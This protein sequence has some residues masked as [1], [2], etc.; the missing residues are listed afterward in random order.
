MKKA[1]LSMFIF[2]IGASS[3]FATLVDDSIEKELEKL[4]I[5]KG[6]ENKPYLDINLKTFKSCEDMEKVMED[7]IKTYWKKNKDKYSYRFGNRFFY[8]VKN[9]E[10][11]WAVMEE[12]VNSVAK[13]SVAPIGWIASS[14]YSKTNTQVKGVDEADIVK[15]DGKYIYYFSN[16]RK[17]E[18]G[19]KKYVY[20]SSVK[21]KKVVKKIEIP[22]RFYSVE[23]YINNNK[24][25]IVAS[26][27]GNNY[28]MRN[29]IN[30]NQ[31]T[32]AIVYD[33][34]NLEKL[35]FD[36]IY[37]L[38][39]S[40]K[41]SRMIWDYLYLVSQNDFS[42]P[43]YDFK[44]ED[45][46][47]VSSD[48]IIPKK[49]SLSY[50]KDK[51]RQNYK[52]YPYNLS[53]WNTFSCNE[54]EYSFPSEKTLEKYGFSPSY[55]IISVIDTKNSDS[56]VKT[57]VVVSSNSEMYMST[58]NIYLTSYLYNDYRFSCP[59]FARCI[60]PYY[61]VWTNTLIHKFGVSG[62]DVGYKK[63]TLVP[64]KP[65]TQYS[66]DEYRG[67][68]RILTQTDNWNSSKRKKFTGLYILDKDLKLKSKLENLW[69]WENFKSSRY[70][71][72]KLY[73]VTFK[74][75]DPF[76]VIDVADSENPKVLWELKMPGYSTYLHPYDN[77]HIIWLWYD[78]FENEWWWTQN[79]GLK[80]DLYEI[81][82]NKKCG[83]SDL[84]KEEK[85]K[86]D[87]WDYK[88]IIAK[89]KY[90]K[91]FGWKW[92]SSEATYNPRMFMWNSWKQKLFL[93][94]TL[95][96]Y[97]EDYKSKDFF[98]GMITF[99]INKNFGIKESY[100]ITNLDFDWIEE[101]MNKECAKYS[102]DNE[103]CEE[104]R[105]GEKYCYSK[106]RRKP[107][108]Y[109][110][111]NST[112]WDYFNMKRWSFEDSF[113]KRALWVGDEVFTISNDKLKSSDMESGKELYQ[114]KFD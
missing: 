39:W 111:K 90:S 57:K 11:D 22:M 28:Y 61:E 43:F 35:R 41:N 101:K 13:K 55:N 7:Y 67:D 105:N 3:G 17:Y 53:V 5:E 87:K 112:A 1:L 36:K 33:V 44:T 20:I 51:K 70:M 96:D 48:K 34:E 84:T 2:F 110:F 62:S 12:S 31:K 25:I 83:D 49:V 46:I 4:D 80:L 65:L 26:G 66:M 64:W 10:L 45:D 82:Y 81:N 98:Q 56:E 23:L 103:V 60:M 18:K 104:L 114:V 92:S 63:S 71:W 93:P 40:Y 16:K 79:W 73:L 109:C 30:R 97:G 6:G 8:D 107:P 88:W 29:I 94:V 21:D 50:T 32:Y 108:I 58:N 89:Q 68:F 102:T 86:C 99:G 54:V 47:E 42:F 24:L 75:I 27:Q 113:I 59:P 72:D 77:N 9:A 52:K 106:T 14:D 91:V 38:E 85:E 69:D 19:S 74:D 37:I 15:T 100:R 76:F 78:T 95:R